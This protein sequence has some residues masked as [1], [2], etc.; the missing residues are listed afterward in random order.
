MKIS[1]AELITHELT[2]SSDSL[3]NYFQLHC[4]F[5]ENPNPH[6]SVVFLPLVDLTHEI[7]RHREDTR[8]H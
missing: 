2:D 4:T 5:L 6:I 8:N 7:G 1:E 3:W